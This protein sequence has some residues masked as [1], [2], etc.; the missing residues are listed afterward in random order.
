MPTKVRIA[1][2]RGFYR[3]TVYNKQEQPLFEQ[4]YCRKDS[5]YAD[6]NYMQSCIKRGY[7]L[8]LMGLGYVVVAA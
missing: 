1:V 2:N 7:T 4:E 6:A 3:V 5:A 8:E